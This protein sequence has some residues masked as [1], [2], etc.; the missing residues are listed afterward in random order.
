MQDTKRDLSMLK[1][2]KTLI[3]AARIASQTYRRSRDLSR[4]LGYSHPA[5]NSSIHQQLFDLEHSINQKRCLG[6]ASYD[7]KTH[8]QVLSALLAEVSVDMQSADHTKLSGTEAFF[9]TT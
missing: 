8:V 6:D 4:V 9:C 7:L 3:S 2:P 5:L 1:R